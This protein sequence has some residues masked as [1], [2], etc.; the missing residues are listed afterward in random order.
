[1]ML[2]LRLNSQD[3]PSGI[4]QDAWSCELPEVCRRMPSLPRQPAVALLLAQSCCPC[5]HQPE[6][7][8]ALGGRQ[9]TLGSPSPF[10]LHCSLPPRRWPSLGHT[11]PQPSQWHEEGRICVLFLPVTMASVNT[12]LSA[13]VFITHVWSPWFLVPLAFVPLAVLCHLTDLVWIVL[14]SK[15]EGLHVDDQKQIKV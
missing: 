6:A 1:M 15:R 7:G 14:F 5:S 10:R 4:L 2:A 3:I 12:R 13:T 11:W 9:L 8:N